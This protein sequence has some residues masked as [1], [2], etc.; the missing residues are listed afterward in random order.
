MK[1]VYAIE[2]IECDYDGTRYMEKSAFNSYRAVSYFLMN[3]GYSVQPNKV[4]SYE[5]SE[6]TFDLL[7]TIQD[8]YRVWQADIHELNMVE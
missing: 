2:Y 4:Y 8:D 1:K 7:W 6:E 5:K 3:M